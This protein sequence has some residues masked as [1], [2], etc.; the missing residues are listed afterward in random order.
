MPFDA[1]SR[2]ILTRFILFASISLFGLACGESGGG[3]G[4][5]STATGSSS[6]FLTDAASDRFDEIRVT[7]TQI[8]FRGNGA[9][10]EIFSGRET[11]DLK[12]LENFSDLFVYSDSVPVGRYNKIRLAVEEVTLIDGDEVISVDP[13]ANG[14]IDRRAVLRLLKDQRPA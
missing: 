1:R 2:S 5:A 14:K 3:G 6:I 11:I 10:V 13:P 8:E 12:D 9:P 7:L 4:E